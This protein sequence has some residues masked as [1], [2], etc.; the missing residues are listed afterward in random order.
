[1][2]DEDVVATLPSQLSESVAIFSQIA[3]E[4]CLHRYAPDKW[5]SG[6]E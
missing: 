5:T 1:V 6:R 2:A 4:K 3:E